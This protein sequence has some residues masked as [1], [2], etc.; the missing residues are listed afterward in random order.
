VALKFTSFFEN[1]LGDDPVVTALKAGV[2][3][4]LKGLVGI[5]SLTYFF[6]RF[7]YGILFRGFTKFI[8]RGAYASVDF[9]PIEHGIQVLIAGLY[10][11][12]MLLL[13]AQQWVDTMK[14]F[15]IR[16]EGES[17]KY[18]GKAVNNIDGM[19]DAGK[20]QG[21]I[22]PLFFLVQGLT[23]GLAQGDDK[24]IADLQL[25][26]KF[27]T[28]IGKSLTVFLG[29]LTPDKDIIV[30]RTSF[31]TVP[32]FL[33]ACGL[34]LIAFGYLWTQVLDSDF[35]SKHMVKFHGKVFRRG[36]SP[37]L[38]YFGLFVYFSI[39]ALSKL[40]NCPKDPT[41]SAQNLVEG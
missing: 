27:G 6:T 31:L 4:C 3:N 39:D 10:G 18:Y 23:A 20:I 37:L 38:L 1:T 9:K 17:W 21:W 33:A 41:Q 16:S 2:M 5:V 32:Y 7:C 28:G 34:F 22:M 25:W 26:A 8:S 36:H 35:L 15:P 24:K 14:N 11:T 12:M 30:Y 29:S 19:I 13:C 40:S